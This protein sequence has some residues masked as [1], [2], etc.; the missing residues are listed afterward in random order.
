MK[1]LLPLCLIILLASSQSALSQ[2]SSIN[3]TIVMEY[4]Q[5]QQFREALEYVQPKFLTSNIQDLSLYAY[6]QYLNGNLK[7]A[8]TQYEQV[9]QLDSNQLVAHQYLTSIYKDKPEDAI[10]HY[11]HIIRLQ[12]NNAMAFRQLA[13]AFYRIKESD[14]AFFFLNKSY[15]L[16]SKDPIT[17]SRLAD[18]LI[19]R[20][21]FM[22]ADSILCSF[23]ETDS[24]DLNVIT[25]SIRLAWRLGDYSRCIMFG[26]QMMNAKQISTAFS[27]V[28]AA[29]YRQKQYKECITIYDYLAPLNQAS[30]NIMYFTALAHTALKN[31]DSSNNL[32]QICIDLATSVSLDDYYTGKSANYE[33]MKQ[34]KSAIAALDT[35]WYLFQRPLRQYS[36]GRIYDVNLGN[37]QKAI[38]HYKRYLTTKPESPE[39]KA[40]YKYLKE[41]VG[42]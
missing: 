23:I 29:Q 10:P 36:I 8:A 39:E 9:L 33:G 32:L 18:E 22:R 37:K 41:Y 40:I 14:T 1:R 31:Y 7:E 11:L 35:A 25:S 42:K 20:N 24:T 19:D 34:Y 6:L 12:P 4:V 17:A 16:N 21:N 38:V 28:I 26:N 5:N 15:S 3:K 13:F 30:P 27:Y 2:Q